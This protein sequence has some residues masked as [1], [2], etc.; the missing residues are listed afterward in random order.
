MAGFLYYFPNAVSAPTKETLP[1]Q[2]SGILDGVSLSTRQVNCG[3]DR[4]K[5]YVAC[6]D[7]GST[8]CGFYED[9]QTWVKTGDLWTGYYR[10]QKPGPADLERTPYLEGYPII[11]CDGKP[12][13]IPVALGKYTTLQQGFRVVDGNEVEYITVPGYE[14][15]VETAKIIRSAS[16]EDADSLEAPDIDITKFAVTLLAVNYRVG[17]WECS[18]ELLNLLDLTRAALLIYASIDGPRKVIE[19]G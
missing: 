6:V 18:V 2:L 14:Y 17:L 16:D 1:D 4:M 8:R 11:L 10:D 19:D 12:W 13:V 3:P 9:Q 7:D 5:G 15:I